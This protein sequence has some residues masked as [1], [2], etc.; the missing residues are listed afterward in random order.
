MVSDVARSDMSDTIAL[1]DAA[2][3]HRRLCQ[4]NPSH[5][6]STEPWARLPGEEEEFFRGG[7]RSFSPPGTMASLFLPLGSEGKGQKDPSLFR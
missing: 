2:A 5:R 4:F 1:D 7:K 3:P 6:S